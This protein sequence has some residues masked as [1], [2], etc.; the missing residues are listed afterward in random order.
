MPGLLSLAI[1]PYA[2]Y[3]LH[4]PEITDTSEARGHAREHLRTMGPMTRDEKGMLGVFVLVLSLWVTATLH[5]I[6]VTSVAYLGIGV[7]LVLG[8]LEW[9]DVV[10][11]SGAWNA[12]MWFGG[13][14]MLAAQ[15]NE[16][17][18]LEAFAG[19]AGGLVEGWPWAA[20]LAVLL[21]IYL[22][23]HYAF[24]SLTAHVTAM[25]PAFFALE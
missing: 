16:A 21:L 15:L 22:Y 19:R 3:R 9:R 10:E 20:A 5:G 14:V 7:L 13:L 24:A 11:E 1:V 2:I 23:S 8:V 18:I 25:F 6:S 17:G 12:L 4:P